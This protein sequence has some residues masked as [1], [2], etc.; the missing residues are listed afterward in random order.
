MLGWEE[1]MEKQGG[2]GG[3]WQGDRDRHSG[4]L[5][6][7]GALQLLGSGTRGGHWGSAPPSLHAPDARRSL[8]LGH[9]QQD[10]RGVPTSP[11]PSRGEAAVPHLS[12]PLCLSLCSPSAAAV[13]YGDLWQVWAPIC[14]AK[15]P[16]TFPPAR[17]SSSPAA[18]TW[19]KQP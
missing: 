2:A 8:H 14:E 9:S 11:P 17:G 13:I 1:G 4:Q 6:T 12:P 7:P 19:C 16:S 10:R 18:H 5:D 3:A 15:P